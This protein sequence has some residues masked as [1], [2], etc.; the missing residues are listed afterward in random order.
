MPQCKYCRRQ[1]ENS[2]WTHSGMRRS[3]IP[4][5][6][7]P[8]C[9]Y[10]VESVKDMG[11]TAIDL[12]KKAG[13]AIMSF[14]EERKKRQKE[15]SGKPRIRGTNEDGYDDILS[16]TDI[17]WIILSERQLKTVRNRIN[18]GLND[19]PLEVVVRHTKEVA[20]RYKNVEAMLLVA[21][22]YR[23][24]K[25]GVDRDYTEAFKWYNEAAKQFD[26]VGLLWVGVFYDRGQGVKKNQ[27]KAFEYYHLAAMKKNRVACFNLGQCF[28]NGEGV[29][30]SDASAFEW[31]LKSAELDFVD[32]QVRVAN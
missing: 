19:V 1:Y 28:S 27:K 17:Q 3:E 5:S 9:Y 23:D 15:P 32:A 24:G 14:F 20:R 7:R 29:E 6:A 18:E 10:G 26:P 4:S 13:T 25:K 11:R 31:W 22:W 21:E 16:L 8:S 30:R 12:G 2:E